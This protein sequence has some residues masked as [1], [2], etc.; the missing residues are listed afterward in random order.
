MHGVCVLT[1]YVQTTNERKKKKKKHVCVCLGLRSFG[2]VF[3]FVG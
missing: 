2:S 1:K 3:F